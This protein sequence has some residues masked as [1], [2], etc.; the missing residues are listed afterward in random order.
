[1]IGDTFKQGLGVQRLVLAA[2]TE[3]HIGNQMR[4]NGGNADCPDLRITGH[5]AASVRLGTEMRAIVGAIG[6]TEGGAVHCPQG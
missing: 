2:L 1:M 6:G 5:L 3:G 4:G